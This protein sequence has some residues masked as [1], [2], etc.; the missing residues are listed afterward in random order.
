ML[1]KKGYI[2]LEKIE[3]LFVAMLI[4]KDFLAPNMYYRQI[5]V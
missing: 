4:F 5:I 1:R 2:I 3:A